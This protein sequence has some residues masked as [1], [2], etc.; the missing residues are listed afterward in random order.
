MT[1]ALAVESTEDSNPECKRIADLLLDI[2]AVLQVSG[3]H[4][5]RIKRNIERVAEH[6]GYHVE[7]FISFTG[8]MISLNEKGCDDHRVVRLRSCP[9]LGVNF[10][11][12][13]EVSLL[14]WRVIE[15]DLGIQQVEERLAE[16][17]KI[18]HHPRLMILIGIGLACA[19]LSLI[20][21]GTDGHMADWHDALFA[22]VAA[23]CGM[24]VRQQLLLWRYNPLVCF[25]AASFTTSLIAGIDVVH[26]LGSS[27]EKVL[28]ASVLYLIPGVPL[29]NS[30]I[31]L[32]EGHIPTGIARG[33][34]GGVVLLC[35]AV[36]MS[37]SIY[38]LGIKNF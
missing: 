18:H 15:E 10:G 23:F 9:L 33:V 36:G 17:K 6:W 24:F 2:A 38:I 27:P 13:T 32:I 25:I 11:M 31:D 35:I 16:I 28:A 37:L 4:T 26:K 14:T 30:T 19:S 1:S 21:K 22:F 5:G 7:L 12:V 20:L 3:A 34:F 8:L 29:I